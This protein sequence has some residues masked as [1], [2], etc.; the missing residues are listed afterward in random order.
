MLDAKS[1][2]NTFGPPPKKGAGGASLFDGPLS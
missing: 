2:L 1:H